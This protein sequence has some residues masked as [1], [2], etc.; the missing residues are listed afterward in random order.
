MRSND[1]AKRLT[2]LQEQIAR[3]LYEDDSHAA[4]ELLSEAGPDCDPVWL[5]TRTRNLQLRQSALLRNLAALAEEGEALVAS[6]VE[7]HGQD[8]RIAMQEQAILEPARAK[9]RELDAMLTQLSTLRRE[10]RLAKATDAAA[11]QIRFQKRIGE[12]TR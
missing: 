9:I 8:Q 4:V 5:E 11:E 6:Y 12:E 7:R 3:L 2:E 10:L 1:P